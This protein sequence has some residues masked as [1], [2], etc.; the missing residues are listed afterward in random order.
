MFPRQKWMSI[1]RLSCLLSILIYPVLGQATVAEQLSVEELRAQSV[2]VVRA[3]VAARYVV[4]ERGPKGE[5]YTQIELDAFEYLTGDGPER[6]RVQQLGGELDGVTLHVEG[7]AHFEV[8]DEI[9]AFLDHDPLTGISY[10]VGLAQGVFVIHDVGGTEWVTRDL[11][12]ISF[13]TAGASPYAVVQS[14]MR[15]LDLAS[16]LT[17][18]RFDGV[19]TR[20]GGLNR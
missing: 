15:Y 17:G 8:G 5:I 4:P 2:F 16:R 12:G 10:V 1:L 9:V 11:D 13:Y 3:Y 6:L 18:P 7:N 14:V 20:D 19:M